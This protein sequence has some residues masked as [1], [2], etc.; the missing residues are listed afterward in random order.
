MATPSWSFNVTSDGRRGFRVCA[1]VMVKDDYFF[2]RKWISYY[3]RQLGHENLFVIS[4]GGDK[5]VAEIA[6]DANVIPIP[7]GRDDSIGHKRFEID[8]FGLINDFCSGLVRYFQYVIFTDVDEFIIV[9]PALGIGLIEYI[10]SHSAATTITPFGLDVIHRT[11]QE[12]SSIDPDRPVL[13]QR[14]YC[15]V[16]P[17][18]SKPAI[19][20]MDIIRSVGNHNSNDSDLYLGSGLYLFH[21]KWVD[22]GLSMNTHFNRYVSGLNQPHPRNGMDLVDERKDFPLR[23]ALEERFKLFNELPVDARGFDFEDEKAITGALIS[24]DFHDVTGSRT[25]L[26]LSCERVY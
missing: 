11:A 24:T 2:L 3:G 10:R 22:Y 13:S 16:E 14:K 7:A 25:G 9:D 17:L 6:R 20:R 18:Y 1:V 21:L 19:T 4:H 23:A 8:R 12:P 26:A 15:K 5:T